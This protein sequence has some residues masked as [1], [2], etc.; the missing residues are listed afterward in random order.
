MFWTRLLSGIVLL[1][2]AFLTILPGGYLLLATTFLICIVGLGEYLSVFDKMQSKANNRKQDELLSSKT[3]KCSHLVSPLAIIAYIATLLYFIVLHFFPSGEAWQSEAWQSQ[4][5]MVLLLMFFILF[6]VV[7]AQFLAVIFAFPKYRM[8]EVFTTTF[9]FFYVVVMLSFL[10]LTRSLPMGVYLVWLI[11][12]CAWGSDTLAY[13]SGMLFGK[14][15]LAPILS[16]KKSI[17]GAIGG[18]LGAAFL[19]FLYAIILNATAGTAFVPYLFAILGA[20]ASIISQC[21]DLAAS[22]IKR[23]YDIKDFGRIIPG[24][25]G[26]MDR[27]DSIIVVAPLI[28]FVSY[29]FILM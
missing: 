8:D 23:N 24:H 18:V 28:F 15:K 21:G 26:I 19:A 17:E 14:H 25:G 12:I 1:L 3:K 29:F 4:F 11:F 27:F 9:G 16:P 5:L 7:I 6:V 10:Y 20:A 13:C 22:A 2:V